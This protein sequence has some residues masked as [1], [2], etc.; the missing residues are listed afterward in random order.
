VGA[1]G[2]EP[3]RARIGLIIPSVNQLTEPQ[4]IR[5]APP[6]VQMHFTRFPMGHGHDERLDELIERVVEAG[7]L[8][9]DAA[10]DVIIFHCTAA[11][12]ASGLAGNQRI[13][14]ALASATGRRAASTADAVLAALK[15]LRA[16]KIVFISPYRRTS[17][18]QE[19]AFLA[20]AGVIAVR[21]RAL[22]LPSAVAFTAVSPQ[23]WVELAIQ[24]AHP[25]AD[26]YFLSCTNIQAPAALDQIESR[27]SQPAIS[28]NQATLWYSL[29]LCGVQAEVPGLGQLL[30]REPL[31]APV[32]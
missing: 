22:E 1:H 19:L 31:K 10:C 4:F 2:V 18:D 13:V 30:R 23:Q 17:H 11:S 26:A 16:R 28:S 3:V 21:E 12:M 29:R 6:G 25:G 32:L 5:Y 7:Q 27:L 9:A 15:M 14:D 24:E 20:E 8:L